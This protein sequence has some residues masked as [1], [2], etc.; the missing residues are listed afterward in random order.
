MVSARYESN[1]TSIG[2]LVI[3]QYLLVLGSIVTG[4]YFCLLIGNIRALRTAN[5]RWHH[6]RMIC[7]AFT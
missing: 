2:V 3:G 7:K 4:W 1:D 6:R 5:N